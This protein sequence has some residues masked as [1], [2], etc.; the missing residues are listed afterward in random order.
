M[1]RDQMHLTDEI[2]EADLIEQRS[3]LGVVEDFDA[4]AD[5]DPLETSAGIADEADLLEQT[6]RLPVDDEDDYPHGEPEE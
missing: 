3:S 5:L 1:A 4:A 6:A 2:P